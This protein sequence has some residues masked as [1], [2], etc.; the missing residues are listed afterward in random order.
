MPVYNAL[1]IEITGYDFPILENYQKFVHDACE[2]FDMSVSDCWA[3]PPKIENITRFKPN[4]SVVEANYT[5]KTYKR[6]VQIEQV[7]AHQ[8][9]LLVRVIQ[10]GLPEG[11][12]FSLMEHTELQ[13]QDRYVPD[14]ELLQLKQDLDD[15]GG[16]IE[17]K[18][19]RR[20]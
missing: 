17:K 6:I 2:T 9:P 3:L 11:V 13:E 4:S 14:K 19:K 20:R 8:V 12:K 10:A 18:D 5:L 1:N 15:I 16:P 7:K